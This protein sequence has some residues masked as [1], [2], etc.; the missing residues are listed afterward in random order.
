MT[1]LR[2]SP[3]EK[4]SSPAP[5]TCTHNLILKAFL[6]TLYSM[7]SYQDSIAS[8][9]NRHPRPLC[10]TPVLH[11]QPATGSVLAQPRQADARTHVGRA[12]LA[13]ALCHP[14]RPLSMKSGV[15]RAP[16]LYT[17]ASSGYSG[18]A[19]SCPF[20]LEMSRHFF[21]QHKALKR[22]MMLEKKKKSQG[23]LQGLLISRH[24]WRLGW[25]PSSP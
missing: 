25:K 22:M 10:H 15:S 17:L 21:V 5:D 20:Q 12:G 19:H 2:R 14:Q 9:I 3:S 8:Q 24:R 18:K 4:N 13:S 23:S 1:G 7:R 11:R 16:A 6:P